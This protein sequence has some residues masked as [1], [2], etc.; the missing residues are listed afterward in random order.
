[1][2]K[3]IFSIVG[4]IPIVV[5]IVFSQAVFAIPNLLVQEDGN[6]FLTPQSEFAID[7]QSALE[8]A[9]QIEMEL[10]Q[11]EEALKRREEEKLQETSEVSK[12]RLRNIA[13]GFIVFIILVGGTTFYFLRRK[14]LL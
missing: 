7:E 12:A 11:K 13:V 2:K 5:S 3:S 9:K 4:L 14:S 8:E 1:M 10:K 6:R